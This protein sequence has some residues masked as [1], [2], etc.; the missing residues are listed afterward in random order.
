MRR[1][2][3]SLL[4]LIA[5]WSLFYAGLKYF[6]WWAYADTSWHPTLE[7]ISGFVLTGSMIA[8]VIGWPLYARYSERVMLMVAIVLGMIFFVSSA[9]LPRIS[10][11]FFDFSM[12]GIGLSY[13]LY[14]IGK[15]TLIGR[16]I[17]T[18]SLGSSS[19]GAFTTVTFIVFLIAG[20]ILWAKMGETSGLFGVWVWVFLFLLVIAGIDLLFADTSRSTREFQFS[21]DLYRRLFVRYGIFMIGLGCFWQ[22]SVEA[23]QV[24]INYS[25]DFFDKSNSAA[26]LLLLFSSVGAI[27]GNILSVK[28]SNSRSRS[29]IVMT[30]CFIVIIFGFSSLLGLAKSLDIYLIV[31]ILAFLVGFFFGWAVN[32]AESHFYGLLGRDPDQDYTSALYGF[33]LSLVG[34]VTMF[35]SEHILHTGSYTGISVFLG[36]LS[37]I[38]LYGGWRGIQIEK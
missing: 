12:V 11:Y 35:A 17:S 23:S 3:F 10:P 28:L 7:G 33:T 22:I 29:F 21:V 1:S 36:C 38:A 24:A 13:S 14:V 34:A 25:K 32:L 26:S 4:A 19:I 9:T 15:N 6:F 30:A 5:L 2:L 8:Y 31:Q 16:E 27:L 20:T 18:S 37:L